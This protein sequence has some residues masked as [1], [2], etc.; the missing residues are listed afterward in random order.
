[1]GVGDADLMMMAGAFLGWQVVVIASSCRSCRGWC[2]P[3]RN[4][5]IRRTQALPFGPSL[6]VGVVLTVLAWPALGNY[7]GPLFFDKWFLSLVFGGGAMLLFVLALLLWVFRWLM[8]ARGR[9]R[10]RHAAPTPGHGPVR[11]DGAPTRRRRSPP[12]PDAPNEGK[13]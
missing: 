13:S 9:R 5:I 4:L 11:P 12:A 7:V 10:R 3:S 1:M 2:S 8:G 6:A